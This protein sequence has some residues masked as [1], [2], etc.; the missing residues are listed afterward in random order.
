MADSASTLKYVDKGEINS[1]EISEREEYQN[2]SFVTVGLNKNRDKNTIALL[3]FDESVTKDECNNNW[4]QRNSPLLSSVSKFDYNS[5]YIPGNNNCIYSE[6]KILNTSTW[7]IEC[8]AYPLGFPRSWNMPF[9]GGSNL[10]NESDRFFISFISSKLGYGQGNGNSPTVAYTFTAN[11]WYHIAFVVNNTALTIYINGS[12]VVAT[13]FVNPSTPRYVIIGEN[14][15]LNY[16]A[17]YGYIS[18]FR[19][20]NIARYTT[21]FVPPTKPYIIYSEDSTPKL[22]LLQSP[23][24]VVI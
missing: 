1:F 8:W 24:S 17:F 23:M 7:T 9:S 21:N 4:I 22:S 20:S 13:T 5:L 6:D 19:V 16:W 15:Q 11:T 2:N 18:E 3:H 12:S 10:G 14:S